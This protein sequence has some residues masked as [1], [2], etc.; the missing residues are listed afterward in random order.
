MFPCQSKL[1]G[2][3]SDSDSDEASQ[4]IPEDPRDDGQAEGA[5]RH[6]EDSTKT[7]I[8]TG[9]STAG[10]PATSE[11]SSG[12]RQKRSIDLLA[13]PMARGGKKTKGRNLE[14][15]LRLDNQA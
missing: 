6:V 7:P 3:Q 11:A 12:K 9:G 1:Q 14:G 15:N 10:I 13:E 2:F 8:G 4:A 5:K